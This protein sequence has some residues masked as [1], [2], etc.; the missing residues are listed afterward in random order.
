MSIQDD[1]TLRLYIEESL[2]HLSDIENDLLAIESAGADIDEDVVNKVFRAAHSI[3]GG[4]GFM[5][6][7]NI[8]ELSHRMENILGMI[9]E[10]EM[11]P[12]PEII[13]IL[14]LSSDALRNLLGNVSDS[15]EMDISEHID[16][17]VELTAN[18]LSDEE[19]KELSDQVDIAF[20]D[21]KAVFTVAKFDISNARKKGSFIYLV[22]Y[23][24]IHD[25]HH[26][27]KTPLGLLKKMQESGVILDC[28]IDIEAVGFLDSNI[29]SNRIPFLV[30]YATIL[31]P[32]M[33][34]ALFEIE[35]ERIFELT[36]DM[37]VK[38]VERFQELEIPISEEQELSPKEESPVVKKTT[39]VEEEPSTALYTSSPD[40]KT[41]EEKTQK[42]LPGIISTETSL[43]VSVGLLDN[44]MNLAGELVL[45][46]NQFLQSI[47]LRVLLNHWGISGGSSS[48]N[49]LTF[50]LRLKNSW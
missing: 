17:L 15:N 43:R 9:R 8:K 40:Q 25:I 35:E 38:P 41:E 5:G 21:G 16:A 14:L 24:L 34:N 23:D 39:I 11:V 30:L 19:Q 48:T 47:T 1:D 49:S 18:S 3:K 36:H 29:I 6:L 32:D 50:F 42:T 22:E 4:A 13:N 33:I 45:G 12:N 7:N 27:D 20:P 10:R 44:L 37:I 26:K 46:R 31:E 2:E 28:K